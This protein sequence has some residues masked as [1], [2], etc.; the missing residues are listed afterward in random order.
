MASLRKGS[1]ILILRIVRVQLTLHVSI[2]IVRVPIIL[3][4]C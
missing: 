1:A 3:S 4:L 2:D